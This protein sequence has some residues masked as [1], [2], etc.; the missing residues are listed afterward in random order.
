[1]RR[2][3][4]FLIFITGCIFGQQPQKPDSSLFDFWLGEW[5]LTWKDPDGTTA[6]GTNIVTKTLDGKVIQENFSG[7]S[8]QSKGYKGNSVSVL[9]QRTGM[10]KQTWV[11]NQS[12]YLSFTGGADGSDR[13]FVEEFVKNG[14]VHKGKMIFRN[15]SKD[16]LLWDWKVSSNGGATWTDQWS[17]TYKRKQR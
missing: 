14:K 7:L 9:D 13:Y 1:M 11:D 12:A 8:G 5:D 16:S 15:I 10:W 3:F 6:S 2:I 4:F 17:I